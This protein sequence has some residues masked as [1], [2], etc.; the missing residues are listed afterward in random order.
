MVAFACRWR[1]LVDSV[2]MWSCLQ[3]P[4]IVGDSLVC[5]EDDQRLAVEAGQA[6]ACCMDVFA[7]AY[8]L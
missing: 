5:G 6:D 8:S 7:T 1:L 3:L 4:L 2:A